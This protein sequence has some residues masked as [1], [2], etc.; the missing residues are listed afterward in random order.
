M[1]IVIPTH[2]YDARKLRA[3]FSLVEVMLSVVIISIITVALSL[4][5][6]H[7]KEKTESYSVNLTNN[8]DYQTILR[9]IAED[10][11]QATLIRLYHLDKKYFIY[12]NTIP[13]ETVSYFLNANQSLVKYDNYNS[14]EN[15]ETLLSSVTRFSFEIETTTRNETVY[16]RSLTIV[17]TIESEDESV[18][19]SHT[20]SLLNQPLWDEKSIQSPLPLF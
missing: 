1:A 20:V 5:L 18:T 11:R 7:T 15:Y 3:G 13:T 2:S 12:K 17:L 10:C 14:A 6:F 8:Q 19:H 16:I 4:A 9:Q